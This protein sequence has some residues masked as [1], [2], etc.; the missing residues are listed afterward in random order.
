[1]KKIDLDNPHSDILRFEPPE[2]SII[3]TNWCA[4]CYPKMELAQ[5]IFHGFSLCKK[6]MIERKKQTEDILR[7]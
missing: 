5:F 3:A 1:M 2:T 7:K 4:T 6:C